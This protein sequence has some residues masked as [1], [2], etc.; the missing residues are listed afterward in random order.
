MSA[1]AQYEPF[2]D[3]PTVVV[4]VLLALAFALYLTLRWFGVQVFGIALIIVVGAVLLFCLTFP[5]L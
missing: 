3:E 1:V 5:D 2:L 4:L